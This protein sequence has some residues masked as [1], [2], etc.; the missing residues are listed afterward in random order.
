MR[1]AL[2]GKVLAIGVW[3]SRNHTPFVTELSRRAKSSLSVFGNFP[4][5]FHTHYLL[6]SPTVPPLEPTVLPKVPSVTV[7]KEQFS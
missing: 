6:L 1:I 7:L 2:V 3:G 5:V 4:I